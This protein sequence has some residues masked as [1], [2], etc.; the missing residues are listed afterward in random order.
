M[1]LVIAV[2]GQKGGVGKTTLSATI[3]AIWVERGLRV[4]LVDAD[5]QASARTW[6]DVSMEAGGSA[7]TI[8]A[9]GQGLHRPDQLPAMKN[10]FDL[11]VIDCPPANGAVQRAALMVADLVLLPCSPSPVDL[12]ALSSSVALVEEA[13]IVRPDL[14]AVIVITKKAPRT[15]I[16]AQIRESLQESNLPILATEIH[17]RVAYAEAMILGQS[18]TRYARGSKAAEEAIALVDEIEQLMAVPSE[19]SSDSKQE[20]AHAA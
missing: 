5:P 7:P 20:A 15:A 10:A 17:N 16:G 6:G 14:K 1:A 4:L 11:V 3:S 8:V 18:V 12:W 9:M 19:G 13:S 2:A